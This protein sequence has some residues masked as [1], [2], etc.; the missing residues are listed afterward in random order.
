MNGNVEF[1]GVCLC[2]S[3]TAALFEATLCAE[4]I[5]G[6][7]L[8]GGDIDEGVAGLRRGEVFVRQNLRI[9]RVIIAEVLLLEALRIDFVFLRELVALGC[10]EGAELAHGLRGEGFA[11]HEKQDAANEL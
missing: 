9:E 3:V 4:E 7:A 2:F 5:P 11:V 8:D 10:A 1:I 6:H